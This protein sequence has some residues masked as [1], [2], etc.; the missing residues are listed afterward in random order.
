MI[1]LRA[2]VNK[3]GFDFDA[4][5]LDNLFAEDLLDI[6]NNF[7]ETDTRLLELTS[8]FQKIFYTDFS[9][10]TENI[11]SDLSF[12]GIDW[13][14]LLDN[15]YITSFNI[16]TIQNCV[17]LQY[18]SLDVLVTSVGNI[19]IQGNS[20]LAQILFPL[21]TSC[22]TLNVTENHAL[23]SLDVSSLVTCENFILQNSAHLS[24]ILIPV[25]WPINQVNCFGNALNEACIDNILASLDAGGSENG[26]VLL[27]GGTNSAPSSA[28]LVSQANLE[29]KGWFVAHN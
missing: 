10:I 7:I 11:F 25:S 14:T 9:Y 20:V 6:E 15:E 24:T 4:E 12:I 16:I 27:G 8:N 2:F 18:L 13:V 3:L 29:A 28:G 19:T 5:K 21:M 23:V 1:T 26:Q 17:A 22:G